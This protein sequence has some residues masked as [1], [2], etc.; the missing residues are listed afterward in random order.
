MKYRAEKISQKDLRLAERA[1]AQAKVLLEALERI[2]E[3][4]QVSGV[5]NE[6]IPANQKDDSI[7][8]WRSDRPV[9]KDYYTKTSLKRKRMELVETLME[10]EK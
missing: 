1:I 4:D 2:Q 9:S 5:W 10:L 3:Y 7:E 6:D 8:A